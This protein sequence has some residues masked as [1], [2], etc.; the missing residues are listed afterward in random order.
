MANDKKT[1]AAIKDLEERY[2]Q[3]HLINLKSLQKLKKD[4]KNIM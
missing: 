3:S 1:S 4:Y 2:A